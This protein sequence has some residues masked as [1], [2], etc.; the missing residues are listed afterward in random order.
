MA[1][2]PSPFSLGDA[3][4][5]GG[6]SAS[7]L[8]TYNAYLPFYEQVVLRRLVAAGCTHNIVMMDAR[9]L[10]RALASASTRP[11]RA[12]IDYTLVPVAA[13]GA[14]HPKLLLRLGRRKGS[15]FVG[16]HN[17][18]MAGFGFND[19]L[20]NRFEFSPD[21]PKSVIG[22]FADAAN[23]IRSK[24]EGRSAKVVEAVDAAM[25]MAASWLNK[26]HPV[27]DDATV[28]V[29]DKSRPELL[30]EVVRLVDAPVRRAL[31]VAPFFDT[32]LQF[33]DALLQRL[34]LEKVTVAI[35]PD[36][37][38][39][40]VNKAQSFG[41]ARF[42][43]ARSAS[44]KVQRRKGARPAY[45]HAKAICLETDDAEI[46]VSGSANASAAAMLDGASRNAEVIVVRRASKGGLATSLG[47]SALHE[48]PALSAEHWSLVDTRI[49]N[50]RELEKSEGES[51]RIAGLAV[52]DA[53]SVEVDVEVHPSDVP[54]LLDSAFRPC[55]EL[56]VATAGVPSTLKGDRAEIGQARFLSLG[57]SDDQRLFVVHD[58]ARIADGYT[59]GSGPELRKVLGTLE[60]DPAQLQTLLKLSEKVIFGGDWTVETG[61]S[62]QAKQRAK[63]E[64]A[65]G[66][67]PETLA[68]EAGGPRGGT[69]RRAVTSGDIIVL[70]DAILQRLG[71]GLSVVPNSATGR[72]EEEER[73]ADDETD[74]LPPPA[75]QVDLRDLAEAC[76]KKVGTLLTKLGKQLDRAYTAVEPTR[77]VVQLAVVL[78]LVRALRVIQQRDEWRRVQETLVDDKR[79]SDF[80]WDYMPVL[81]V[82]E[83]A[84]LPFEL[85][86]RDGERSEEFSLAVGLLVW[87]AWESRIDL[88]TPPFADESASELEDRWERV[89]VLAYV[90][91]WF[92][93]DDVAQ[94]IARDSVRST[95]R[96][97]EDCDDWLDTHL[98]FLTDYGAV[99][100][101]PDQAEEDSS[102]GEIGDVVV[103]PRAVTP[104]VRLVL[105]LEKGPRGM[106]LFVLE[107]GGVKDNRKAYVEPFARRVLLP[108]ATA[109]ARQKRA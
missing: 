88:R 85:A 4:R 73:D 50:E 77:A 61:P 53:D 14:F 19:E 37:V 101:A 10:G 65:A 2:K 15:L 93:S 103:L 33:L 105:G 42:V 67:N 9:Q 76:R 26:P 56:V 32:K 97:N 11:R 39:I 31:V 69:R 107:E 89:Q 5:E 46:V 66:I 91:P 30:D 49:R 22:H 64:D 106:K 41:R 99:C 79:L 71:E 92:F 75:S 90:A 54:T 18:T 74:E 6:F 47:L 25:T 83:E 29:G 63:D 21:A 59:K 8:T 104:R 52:V 27:D 84:I 48:A 16:S 55:G 3:V 60:E 17:L 24:I 70:L 100:H 13:D 87:A 109:E 1:R 23:F 43:D 7:I 58:P 86:V 35:D 78:G 62:G 44:P 51:A 98:A 82:G 34:E 20:T 95:P 102:P 72:T 45:L 12:G 81:T 38:M 68:L 36:S 80:L 108:A 96:R 40:P 94:T 28:I 57:G